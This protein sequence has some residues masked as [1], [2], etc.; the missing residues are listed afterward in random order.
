M[1]RKPLTD[2][3]IRGIKR[4]QYEYNMSY[5]QVMRDGRWSVNDFIAF[6][7]AL[8]YSSRLQGHRSNSGRNNKKKKTK[9]QSKH[10]FL[11]KNRVLTDT[12]QRKTI[13]KDGS[14]G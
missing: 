1:K 4:L 6:G 13:I 3:A 12:I 10:Q 14:N 5:E 2:Q 9:I 7:E 8:E 11:N